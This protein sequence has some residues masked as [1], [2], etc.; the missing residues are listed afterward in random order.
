M[1]DTIRISRPDHIHDGHDPA[2]IMDFKVVGSYNW[3]DETTP[4]ILVPGEYP[5]KP[6]ACHHPVLTFSLC[7]GIPPVWNPP[8]AVSP[9]QPDSGPQYVDQNADRTPGSPLQPMIRAVQTMQPGFNF[10]AVN[11]ITDRHPIRKLF[12]FVVA[13]TKNPIRFGVTILGNTALFTRIDSMTR[14]HS[15]GFHGYRT[16]F[17]Q[18]HTRISVSAEGSTSHH[19]VVNY[20]FRGMN[21][22]VRYAVD[23]Y[24][25]A[26]AEEIMLA[27]GIEVV[28]TGPLVGCTRPSFANA[29]ASDIA[30]PVTVVNGG[31]SIPHAATVELSTRIKN[32]K[33]SSQLESKLPDLWISQTPTFIEALHRS[34]RP[35]GVTHEG[36]TYFDDIAL[37][38]TADLVERWERTNAIQ[39]QRLASVLKDVVEATKQLGAPCIVSCEARQGYPGLGDA[40][41][42]V[43]K[44]GKGEIRS[45]PGDLQ[46]LFEV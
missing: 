21:L 35:G 9:L 44:A 32:A 1:A 23:A 27:D 16:A 39:L 8:N 33:K 31:H 42:K 5:S 38:P 11:I 19:R 6:I 36:S 2:K 4:T 7:P 37:Y 14:E 28:F 12:E 18:E 46:T 24:F 22:L 34:T 10:T 26:K 30:A 3:L 45:L 17:E 13:E 43:S 15:Q 29:P 25:E 41:L 20:D 40:T